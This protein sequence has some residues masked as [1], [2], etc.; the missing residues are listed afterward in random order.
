MAAAL[1]Y[2]RTNSMKYIGVISNYAGNIQDF[3]AATEMGVYEIVIEGDGCSNAPSF[4]YGVLAAFHTPT[5]VLQLA[6]STNSDKQYIRGKIN[7]S[8]TAWRAI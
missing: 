8:W 5:M 2:S 1:G 3:N 4:P 7:G 6:V